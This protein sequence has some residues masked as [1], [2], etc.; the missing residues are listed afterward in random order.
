MKSFFLFV[1]CSL[2][3]FQSSAQ[4]QELEVFRKKQAFFIRYDQGKTDSIPRTEANTARLRKE[5][6]ESFLQFAT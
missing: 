3:L 4:V 5:L 6:E 2:I 1:L